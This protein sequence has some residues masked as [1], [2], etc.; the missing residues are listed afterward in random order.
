MSATE[1]RADHLVSQPDVVARQLRD[2][3]FRVSPSTGAL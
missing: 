1:P 2:D 3:H